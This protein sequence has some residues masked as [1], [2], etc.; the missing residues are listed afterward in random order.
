LARAAV[1]A[2]TRAAFYVILVL[3]LLLH[4]AVSGDQYVTN[5]PGLQF[6]L[7][8]PLLF[9]VTTVLSALCWAGAAAAK[10]RLVRPGGSRAIWRVGQ[11]PRMGPVS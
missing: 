3:G 6:G 2:A 1:W 7:G 5:T 11:V 10:E 9:P 4:E 8:L